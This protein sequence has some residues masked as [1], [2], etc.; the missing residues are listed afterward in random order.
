MIHL[1][2]FIQIIISTKNDFIDIE[3]SRFTTLKN[4]LKQ[5]I[6]DL[7]LEIE[8]KN[9]LANIFSNKLKDNQADKQIFESNIKQFNK[10][11]EDLKIDYDKL[12]NYEREILRL[13]AKIDYL[14]TL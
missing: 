10:I 3:I 13:E 14:K 12:K 7:Q 8:S 9:K 2:Y 6:S 11:Y 5:Q 4:G 1:I